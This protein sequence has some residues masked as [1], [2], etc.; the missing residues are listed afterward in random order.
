M[1][2]L[3]T[4]P[5]R[6]VLDHK[7]LCKPLTVSLSHLCPRPCRWYPG[8]GAEEMQTVPVLSKVWSCLTPSSSLHVLDQTPAS[9]VPADLQC[10]TSSQF[11]V[12]VKEKTHVETPWPR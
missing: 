4:Q 11:P 8:W 9:W 2:Q 6:L 1:P 3:I 7:P 10:Q 5:G 12:E